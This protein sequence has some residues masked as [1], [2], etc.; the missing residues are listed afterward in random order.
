[1]LGSKWISPKLPA[2]LIYDNRRPPSLLTVR[3]D[4]LH[5]GEVL[6]VRDIAVTT[7]ARTARRTRRGSRRHCSNVECD[8]DRAR[9]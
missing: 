1:M 4:G 6:D 2:E 5:D 9:L 7:A 8:G 3:A